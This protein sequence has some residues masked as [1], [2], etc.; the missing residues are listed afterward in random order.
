MLYFILLPHTSSICLG[1]LPVLSI[2]F[3]LNSLWA[4]VFSI[5]TGVL[6]VIRTLLDDRMLQKELPGYREYTRNQLIP[7]VW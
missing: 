1:L 3:L 5:P 7:G 2:S 6:M 4:L